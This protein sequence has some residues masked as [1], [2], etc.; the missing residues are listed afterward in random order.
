MVATEKNSPKIRGASVFAKIG[1]LIAA[2]T[3]VTATFITVANKIIIDKAVQEGVYALGANMTQSIASRSAGAIRFGDAEK[4]GSTLQSAMEASEG[5]AHHGVIVNLDGEVIASFGDAP[6]EEFA[7]LATI[8]YTSAQ[9]GVPETTGDGSYAAAP[10]IS[11][12]GTVVGAVAIH[13]SSK[14]AK[15]AVFQDQLLAYGI[16]SFLFLVMCLLSAVVLRR[17]I[18][19]PLK[20]LGKSI[21][22]IAEGDYTQPGEYLARADEI[23]RISRNVEN[24]KQQLAE[25][26]DLEET[27]KQQ[28]EVQKQ[29]VDALNHALKQM[30]DGD[31]THAISEPFTEEYETLR[32][33]FNSTRATMVS[34]IDSV[35][36]S[37]ERIRS[38]AEQI[39]V[40]SSDLSQR[41]ESQAATLEETA[42]AM[43]ELNS[44]VRSAADGARH[45]ESIMNDARSTAVES[46]RVVS[47]AVDAMSKI[48]ASS[49]KIS[50]ILT[51]IDDIAFQTNLLALNAGVEAAR[52]GEAGRGFAV[53]ASEVRAL[54]QR[55]S[56]AA[57]EI[58]HLIVES[59]DQVG[60]GVRLV[61]RTGEELEKIIGRVGT[62]SSHVSDIATGAEEQS[63][64]LNEINTGVSQLDQV[65]QHNAAMVEETT[66]ASQVLRNDAAQ[67]ARVV[68]VFKTDGTERR[69]DALDQE[70]APETVAPE[71]TALAEPHEHEADLEQ[72]WAEPEPTEPQP[73][74]LKQAAG[75]DDF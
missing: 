17:V 49:S 35:I 62:I 3:L 59:T 18:S 63:T 42:A 13:W 25:A 32:R 5:R 19:L 64:T 54:A 22:V 34:I 44:S 70:S 52:A 51:V 9:T 8:A 21:D 48:E 43:E 47:D 71:P 33:H 6:E 55:S 11:T 39:S 41:T 1:L 65:T 2:A 58:K 72:Q 45:V 38:S 37:S 7:D 57:Q 16:A 36:E 12:K 40:S 30:S 26:R 28:Q 23:G 60:S 75:W 56:D 61:G 29:V 20:N 74:V 4:L 66:A 73:Q 10:A 67:L 24:L 69:L 53:V 46:G 50:Q 27:R 14:A 15:A 68:A 31:L